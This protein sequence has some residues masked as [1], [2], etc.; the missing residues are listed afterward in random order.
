MSVPWG[1]RSAYVLGSARLVIGRAASASAGMRELSITAVIDGAVHDDGRRLPWLQPLLEPVQGHQGRLMK[2]SVPFSGALRKLVLRGIAPPCSPEDFDALRRLSALRE[3]DTDWTSSATDMVELVASLPRVERLVMG[4]AV[5]RPQHAVAGRA[6]LEGSSAGG[7]SGG[8]LLDSM[9]SSM[10]SSTNS[11][12]NVRSLSCA[13]ALRPGLLCVEE[14]TKRLPRLECLD[15]YIIYCRPDAVERCFLSCGTEDRGGPLDFSVSMRRFL[16]RP[17]AGRWFLIVQL[18]TAFRPAMSHSAEVLEGEHRLSLMRVLEAVHARRVLQEL[19]ARGEVQRGRL[20]CLTAARRLLERELV[21]AMNALLEV[22]NLAIAD[23][24]ARTASAVV[25]S[26]YPPLSQTLEPQ[27]EWNQESSLEAEV[28]RQTEAEVAA[29]LESYLSESCLSAR[30]SASPL[31]G[32]D[33][34]REAEV[35]KRVHALVRSYLT[36]FPVFLMEPAVQRGEA[37]RVCRVALLAMRT[38][39]QDEQDRQTECQQDNQRKLRVMV[40]LGSLLGCLI[41][42][43]LSLLAASEAQLLVDLAACARQRICLDRMV[44]A[45]W[46]RARCA[47]RGGN[48]Q[49]GLF[50]G[51]STGYGVPGAR[52]ARA[53]INCGLL[54]RVDCPG[55]SARDIVLEY[56]RGT[57]AQGAPLD[58]WSWLLNMAAVVR[59]LYPGALLS[60]GISTNSCLNSCLKPST[61]KSSSSSITLSSAPPSRHDGLRTLRTLRVRL[62]PLH[63]GDQHLARVGLHHLLLSIPPASAAGPAAVLLT[64]EAW[65]DFA[66]LRACHAELGIQPWRQAGQA[67]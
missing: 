34:F 50:S 66:E 23:I 12:M 42:D 40:E 1:V 51:Y 41:Q 63:G 33:T 15:N 44:Q 11:S 59:K 38:L 54:P 7:H 4:L 22:T 18:D 49:G 56:P 21:P 24:L 53:I 58:V 62:P 35:Y 25:E 3:L 8:G 5:T 32:S 64:P 55:V 20:T 67:R 52:A 27:Q 61:S 31:A 65:I 30:S 2:G 26:S 60:G 46:S 28:Q 16:Q 57:D 29:Q 14:A 19:V 47:A 9:N 13:D 48:N 45:A 6:D 36:Q 17:L 10:S 43:K 37:A 39:R